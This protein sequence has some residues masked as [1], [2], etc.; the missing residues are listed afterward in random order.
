MSIR[1]A[2]EAHFKF[3]LDPYF[4]NQKHQVVE[5]LRIEDRPM[6]AVIIVAGSAQSSLPEQPDHL[7]NY[8]VPVN[9]AILSSIDETTVD[10]QNDLI[11]LVTRV[12]NNRSSH[13][14]KV[15]GLY[16][17][18]IYSQ[19]VGQEN[20]GRRMIAALGFTAVVNY[21]PEPLGFDTGPAT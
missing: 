16:V 7:G 9:I 17:Y 1:R 13:K 2:V 12:M 19:E 20:E 11:Q 18:D 14:S 8:N 5:S 6:P 4:S 3:C 10:Q 21:S 15:D